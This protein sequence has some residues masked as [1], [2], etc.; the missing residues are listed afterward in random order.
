MALDADMKPEF[1]PQKASAGMA[2][3][4]FVRNTLS[5][6]GTI[7]AQPLLDA[8][9]NGWLFTG[10][11]IICLACSSVVWALSHHGPRWRA[12]MEQRMK[13]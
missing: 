12:D 5:C 10:L 3:N 2:I 8:I 4:N 13:S 9:G 11:G 1:M 6:I 7:V